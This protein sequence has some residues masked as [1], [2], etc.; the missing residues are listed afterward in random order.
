MLSPKAL[1]ALSTLTTRFA[2]Q[3]ELEDAARARWRAGMR[4][5][6][7]EL[8][9]AELSPELRAA[10]DLLGAEL[11]ELTKSADGVAWLAQHIGEVVFSW[12]SASTWRRD[13][14]LA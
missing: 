12:C 9:A 5:P 6:T 4:D 1:E 10:A 11:A 2:E 13:A 8:L 3:P 14:R 7:I